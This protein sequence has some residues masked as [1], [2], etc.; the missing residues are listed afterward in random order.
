MVASNSMNKT[1]SIDTSIVSM[2]LDGY[3]A[4]DNVFLGQWP[5]NPWNF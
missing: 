5:Q 1:R 4:R 2:L 3:I